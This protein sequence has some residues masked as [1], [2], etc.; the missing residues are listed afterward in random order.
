M[1][2]IISLGLILI[3]F[4]SFS[5]DK[6]THEYYIASDYLCNQDQSFRTNP[7]YK[8]FID[9][10]QKSKSVMCFDSI[11]PVKPGSLPLKEYDAYLKKPSSFLKTESPA[12]Y[13]NTKKIAFK[14]YIAKYPEAWQDSIQ[15]I[16]FF[17]KW[18]FD[19][20]TGIFDKT[21]YS[22]G[23][24]AYHYQGI[25]NLINILNNKYSSNYFE[26]VGNN[27]FSFSTQNV[28]VDNFIYD[29][30]IESD[31]GTREDEKNIRYVIPDYYSNLE[32]P[33]RTDLIIS[34]LEFLKNN[35]DNAFDHEG[36]HLTFEEVKNALSSKDQVMTVDE[37]GNYLLDE[38]GNYLM[39][40]VVIS[41]EPNQVNGIRF[42]ETWY[43]N[44]ENFSIKK[45]VNGVSLLIQDSGPN[46]YIYDPESNYHDGEGFPYIPLYIRLND[47]IKDNSGKLLKNVMCKNQGW[48]K[49][50]YAINKT[51]KDSVYSLFDNKGNKILNDQ[52]KY[53]GKDYFT[54]NILITRTRDNSE[55]PDS[56]YNYYAYEGYSELITTYDVNGVI[57][58]E[59]KVV[60]P[61]IYNE[62]LPIYGSY[63]IV[64]KNLKS[65][66]VDATGKVI[67]PVKYT[68]ITGDDKKI[69]RV[70]D[71]YI[72]SW[73]YSH[74]KCGIYDITG[75]EILPCIFSGISEPYN[76]CRTIST[77]LHYGLTDLE[78]KII[79]DTIY[80]EMVFQNNGLI[81][82]KKDN[83]FGFIDNKGKT[84]IPVNYLYAHDFVNDS[85]KVYTLGDYHYIDKTGK[86]LGNCN[87]DNEY[88]LNDELKIVKV[89][90]FYYSD[91][92]GLTDKSGKEVISCIYDD[93]TKIGENRLIAQKEKLYGLVDFSGKIILPF[94]YQ[95]IYPMENQTVQIIKNNINGVCDLNGNILLPVQFSSISGF[96]PEIYVASTESNE[97]YDNPSG[98]YAFYNS[99]GKMINGVIYDYIDFPSSGLAMFRRSGKYGFINEKLQEINYGK[100]D[101]MPLGYYSERVGKG[102]RLVYKGEMDEQFS[103][104]KFG[105]VDSTGKE[106]VPCKY[107]A[108]LPFEETGFARVFIGTVN[109]ENVPLKGKYGLIND[110]GVQ[111]VPNKYDQIYFENKGLFVVYN[112][113]VNEWGGVDKGKY[114]LM[115]NT[116][117]LVFPII[118]D[119]IDYD[120]NNNYNYYLI[121]G[122][123]RIELDENNKIVKP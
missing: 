90:V 6:K 113:T 13:K 33:E 119:Q 14:D 76:E 121:K 74:G 122:E 53:A 43:Y 38:Y 5:Q 77:D 104:G 123:E 59:G 23:F 7:V 55:A 1:K 45:V 18:T 114:G 105:L 41:Y 17:E 78:G 29:V 61:C 24:M 94:E 54:N 120:Y 89:G 96:A 67:I 47:Q 112:G 10:F 69:L 97:S 44:P 46:D 63:F 86:K 117:K 107:N 82:V 106:I 15:S 28:L 64:K 81:K 75:K 16:R 36:K 115:D 65:G 71:G 92:V 110:K 66:M 118:Y 22:T 87:Y 27:E 9:Y 98:K 95:G 101:W 19:P 93:L 109:A 42:Y 4:L 51:I 12:I 48:T 83:K 31:P 103:K 30:P 25:K 32:L 26:P 70:V 40:D 11:Y 49:L 60:V 20:N 21:V 84:I 79:V 88:N 111:V 37:Y 58:P 102:F 3:T 116:G 35:P 68:E 108:I 72:D 8:A 99:Q 85:C 57:S 50:N 91:L 2:N 80:D 62:I 52:L 100:Y 56:I 39:Q 34:L 73:G